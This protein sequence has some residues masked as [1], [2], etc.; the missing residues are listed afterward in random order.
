MV[1]PFVVPVILGGWKPP[2]QMPLS[3]QKRQMPLTV[4]VSCFHWCRSHIESVS[5]I[6][7]V[8][9]MQK[10]WRSIV[11]T[12]QERKSK[13]KILPRCAEK[14]CRTVDKIFFNSSVILIFT[15][16][17]NVSFIDLLWKGRVKRKIV[18]SVWF[19]EKRSK[20]SIDS[21]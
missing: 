15:E 16:G 2:P 11:T 8:V 10:I 7:Q 17:V 3:C 19:Y 14:E 12:C 21:W 1:I 20:H 6:F 13:I 4:K 9:Q 18:L 5:K